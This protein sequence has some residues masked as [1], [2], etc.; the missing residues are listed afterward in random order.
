MRRIKIN[1]NGVI[2][3]KEENINRIPESPGV[4]EILTKN[5]NGKW[6][7]RYVGSCD[8]FRRRFTEHLS[9]EEENENIRNGLKEYTCG[10]D[11]AVIENEDDYLDAEQGLYDKHEYGWNKNRPEGSGKGDYEISEE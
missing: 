10:F 8:D 4:Y 1:W 7:R 5:D 3:Y 11:Y 9:D 6:D 2:S